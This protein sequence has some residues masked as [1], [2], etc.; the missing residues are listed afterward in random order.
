MMKQLIV[1][2][3]LLVVCV[4]A[5][6]SASADVITP[7]SYFT[8]PLLPII[9]AIEALAFLLASRRW[10]HARIGIWRILI[11]MVVANVA[12]SLLGTFIPLYRYVSENL[13]WIAIALV[14]SVVAEW[15]IY[16]PFF[17]RFES[18]LSR[19]LALSLMT[20]LA[21]YIPIALLLAGMAR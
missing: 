6:A 16:I 7:L 20:N 9:I 19:L 10:L 8:I 14:L 11:A 5:S 18:R 4:I 21:T 12:T 3:T 15:G 2:F 1:H 13:L 17:K